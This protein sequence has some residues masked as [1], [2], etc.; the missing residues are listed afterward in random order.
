VQRQDVLDDLV[1]LCAIATAVDAK[2]GPVATRQLTFDTLRATHAASPVAARQNLAALMGRWQG[3]L[4]VGEAAY[5][6]AVAAGQEHGPLVEDN[7]DLERFFRLPKGHARKIH[8]HAHAGIR[9]VQ[10]GATLVHVLEIHATQPGLLSAEE[11]WPF[12]HATEPAAQCVAVR[13]GTIMR[14]ARSPKL[15]PLLLAELEKRGLTPV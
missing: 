14:R 2:A 13:R 11:L 6:V 3:G 12:R 7:Y 15:R 9:L 10:R 5:E 8:G 4:F 1:V